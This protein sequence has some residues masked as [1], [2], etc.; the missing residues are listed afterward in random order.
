MPLSE[1]SD[2]S[3]PSSDLCVGFIFGKLLIHAN[4]E[5]PVVPDLP[6]ID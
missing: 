1:L 6:L 2:A 3:R 5:S 4:L